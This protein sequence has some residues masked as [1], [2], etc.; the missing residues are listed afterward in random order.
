MKIQIIPNHYKIPRWLKTSIHSYINNEA[1]IITIL[2]VFSCLIKPVPPI[3]YVIG[4]IEETGTYCAAQYTRYNS[5]YGR[6]E[7]QAPY[8]SYQEA[9]DYINSLIDQD[10]DCY[11]N[12]LVIITVIEK[13]KK[14]SDVSIY[15][16]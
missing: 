10:R 2:S 15:V 3:Y 1:H 5:K 12:L 11:N 7:W 9:K 16:P 13:R 4:K 6:F 14:K 8:K